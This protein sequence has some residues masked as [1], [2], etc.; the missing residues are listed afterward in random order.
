MEVFKVVPN[1]AEQTLFPSFSRLPATG[2]ERSRALSRAFQMLLVVTVPLV[3][4]AW[5]LGEAAVDVVF[6]DAFLAATRPWTVLMCTLIVVA[7]SR[8]FLVLLRTSG[9]LRAANLYSGGAVLVNVVL[10]LIWIPR[11][12]PTGAA[13]ATLSSEGVFVALC[14]LE[15]R[16]VA[17]GIGKRVLRVVPSTVVAVLV[18]YFLRPIDVWLAAVVSG[19]AYLTVVWLTGLSAEDR[20]EFIVALRGRA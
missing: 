10:N 13:L 12:G 7:L 19:L 1:L 18:A 2:P 3:V 17:R 8:P 20:R 14:L 4:S 6:G 9:N 15:Q 5:T 16:D 11:Y